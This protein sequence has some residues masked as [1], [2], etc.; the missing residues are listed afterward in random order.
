MEFSDILKEIRLKRKM[1]QEEFAELLQIS[2][3]AVALYETGRRQPKLKTIERYAELLNVPSERLLY[4][5]KTR[6]AESRSE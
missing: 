1:T 3:A 6:R 4:R 5:K 2:R